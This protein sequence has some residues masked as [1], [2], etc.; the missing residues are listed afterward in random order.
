MSLASAAGSFSAGRVSGLNAGAGAGAGAGLAGS[1]LDLSAGVVAAGGGANFFF[2][3]FFS[4]WAAASA[5]KS[6]A[7]TARP[8]ARANRARGRRRIVGTLLR[9]G[10][11]LPSSTRPVPGQFRPGFT[12]QNP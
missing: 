7:V 4:C 6:P 11:V 12:V 2:L 1:G 10:L 9:R 3:P 8:A 5:V